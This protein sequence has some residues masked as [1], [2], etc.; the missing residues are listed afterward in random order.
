MSY[1]LND[2]KTDI[3]T[4]D[5]KSFFD[6]Y[7]M[8]ESIWYI[9][10][11]LKPIDTLQ[12]TNRYKEIV[13][14][15][16]GVDRKNVFM[17]G[18]AKFGFSLSPPKDGYNKLYLPFNNDESVRKLSDIDMT[19]ISEVLFRRFWILYRSSYKLTLESLYVSIKN[20]LYRGFINEKHVLN[21]EGCRAEWNNLTRHMKAQLKKELGFRHDLNLRIY[22]SMEDYYEYTRTGIHKIKKLEAGK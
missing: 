3:V 5:E 16:L 20:D 10:E 11:Y 9:D 4:L 18:S 1:S 12:C 7:Y 6:K 15:F 17:S 22:Y 21:V 14:T 2:I 13:A 19:V 8:G